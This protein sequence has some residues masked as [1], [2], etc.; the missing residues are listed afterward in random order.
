MSMKP[1][2]SRYL[3][4]AIA[5]RWRSIRLFCIGGRRRSSTRCCRRTVSDRFSS[6]SWNGGVGAAFRISISCASTSISPETRFGLAV[7]S[8]RGRTTPGHADHELVAQ[9][10][11]GGER[12]RAVGVADD[13]H[14]ALAVAQVDEDDAAVVAA[15]VDPAHQR[16]GLVQMAAVDAA[17]VVG[18]FQEVL[19]QRSLCSRFERLRRA[20]WIQAAVALA[21][22]I[23]Q[24]SWGGRS[25]RAA[26]LRGRSSGASNPPGQFR[27]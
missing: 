8:G 22:G 4:A 9:R 6:S 5:A 14:E 11:G 18:A 16:D 10:L 21:R 25:R 13:L 3:R 12:R 24:S 27:G 15:A 1:C 20:R 19:R 26:S 23:V 17:A 2:A 7:P